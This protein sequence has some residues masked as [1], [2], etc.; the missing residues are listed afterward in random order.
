MRKIKAPRN[1]PNTKNIL[2][3]IV[4]SRRYAQDQE[5]IKLLLVFS[6]ELLLDSNVNYFFMGTLC[7]AVFVYILG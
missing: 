6:N 7:W 4:N 1:I 2:I 3:C 5:E